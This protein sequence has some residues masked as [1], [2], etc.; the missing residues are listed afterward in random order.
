MVLLHEDIAIL[1]LI[2]AVI[3]E[4]V[5][6]VCFGISLLAGSPPNQRVN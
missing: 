1:L 4:N 3:C 6:E 5:M 2:V